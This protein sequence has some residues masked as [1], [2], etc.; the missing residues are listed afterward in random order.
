MVT[1]WLQKSLTTHL[2]SRPE[3]ETDSANHVSSL[4]I[5][6]ATLFPETLPSL[7]W[8]GSQIGREPR[9]FKLLVLMLREGLRTV[10]AWV[11]IMTGKYNY[12]VVGIGDGCWSFEVQGSPAH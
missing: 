10:R 6:K 1:T 4:F 8:R 3:E 2:H 12:F 9:L 11:F 7:C 5:M